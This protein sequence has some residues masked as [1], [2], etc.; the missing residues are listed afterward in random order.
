MLTH[1]KIQNYALIQTLDIDFHAGFSVITGETGAGKSIILGALGLLLGQRADI[2]TIKQGETRCLVEA[3][4]IPPHS[5]EIQH[6]FEIYDLDFNDKECYLRRELTSNGKN[7]CF[8]NDTPVGL[9]QLKE[10]GTHLIDVHSQHQNLLL[11]E[12]N[13]KFRLLDTLGNTSRTLTTYQ[14]LFHKYKNIEEELNTA[15]KQYETGQAEEDYLRFQLQQIEELSLQEDEQIQLENEQEILN[16]SEEIKQILYSIGQMLNGENNVIGNIRNCV[17]QLAQLN[18]IYNK[19]NDLLERM[20][21]IHIELKDI[22]REVDTQAEAIDFDPQRLTYIENRLNSIYDLEH[23]HKVQNISELSAIARTIRHKLNQTD[24]Q[25]EYIEKLKQEKNTLTARLSEAAKQLSDQRKQSAHFIEKETASHLTKLGMPNTK[26]Q[27]QISDAPL[28][29]NG[30]DKITFLF[31]SNRNASLQDLSQIASGGEIARIMLTLKAILSK[32]I[33]MPTIIFDEIDTGVSGSVA[34]KMALMM[35]EIGQSHSQ[36]ISI[37][38]LPQIASHGT[39]HYLVYKQDDKDGT[40][41]YIKEL[42]NN[43]RIKQIAQMLSGTSL[44]EAAI[45]NAQELL[46]NQ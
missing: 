33:E 4:F 2:K 8:I 17:Q 11:S 16:H 44:T 29:L 36:V 42:N 5:I 24:K 46:N 6:F 3:T 35:K 27:I 39:H 20:E 34:E 12:Q 45:K 19:A 28:S 1:L 21:S 13:F 18:R 25:N 38:H 23:K 30:S 41:S 32:A 26:F 37:T 22:A 40:H 10:L 9:T 31:T 43:E 14:S 7:R 15:I